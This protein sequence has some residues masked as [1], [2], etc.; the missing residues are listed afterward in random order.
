[1]EAAIN[2]SNMAERALADSTETYEYEGVNVNVSDCLV[3]V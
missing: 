2:P 3:E 1:M